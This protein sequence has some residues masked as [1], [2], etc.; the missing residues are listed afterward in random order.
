MIAIAVCAGIAAVVLALLGLDLW[1]TRR[2]LAKLEW[3]E[4]VT[5]ALD[6]AADPDQMD[7]TTWERELA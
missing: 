2:V 5:S 6:V 1:Q 4:H 7:F 3:D